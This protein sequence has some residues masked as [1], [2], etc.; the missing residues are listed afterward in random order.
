MQEHETLQE[1]AFTRTETR[2]LMLAVVRQCDCSF[3]VFGELVKT[4]PGHRRL[5]DTQELK[6]LLFARRLARRWRA[7]EFETPPESVG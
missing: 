2:D 7:G 3:D 1:L 6:R 5:A 4:C